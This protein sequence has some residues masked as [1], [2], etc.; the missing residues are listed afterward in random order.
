MKFKTNKTLFQKRKGLIQFIMRTF[1]LLFCTS[2]FSFSSGTIFS[3]N[4]KVII[5]KDKTVTIDEVFDILR[6]QTVLS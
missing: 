5:D 6:K 3:Q 4:V 1:I 2:V